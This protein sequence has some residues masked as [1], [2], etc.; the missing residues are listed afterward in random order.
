[1]YIPEFSTALKETLDPDLF[2]IFEKQMGQVD[3]DNMLVLTLLRIQDT[4]AANH[5][6]QMLADI[7][8]SI[9]GGVQIR[10]GNPINP[11]F[12]S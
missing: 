2:A 9:D 10:D 7:S 1:M 5:S 11:V 3:D 6:A 8:T 12:R 4:R